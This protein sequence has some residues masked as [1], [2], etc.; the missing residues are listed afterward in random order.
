LGIQRK[1]P[2]IYEIK[3][4]GVRF[5]SV[6]IQARLPLQGAVS[7]AQSLLEIAPGQCAPGGLGRRRPMPVGKIIHSPAEFFI[8]VLSC[9]RMM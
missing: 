6:M 7:A 4:W 5:L 3:P 8:M 2:E 1:K 9:S